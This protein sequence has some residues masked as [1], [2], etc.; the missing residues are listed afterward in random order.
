M[1]RFNWRSGALTLALLGSL[2]TLAACQPPEEPAAP[3]ADSTGPAAG[4]EAMA[5]AEPPALVIDGTEYA[6]AGPAEAQAGLT[7]LTINNAGKEL[8]QVALVQIKDGKAFEDFAAAMAGGGEEYPDFAVPVGGPAVAVPGQQASTFVELEPGYYAM[9]CNIPDATGT[10]HTALGMMR[11]L[12]VAEAAAPS[13]AAPAADVTV[14]GADFKFGTEASYPAGEQVW[15]FDNVGQQ[16][17]ELVLLKLEEGATIGDVAAAFA[18]GGSGQPPALPLGGV[19]GLAP[20]T[21]QAFPV[22]LTA[23]RYGLICFYPDAAS[24][25]VHAE[26]GMMSE[27]D[28]K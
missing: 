22:A 18:P 11:P 19:A 20:G 8:H 1:R 13:A 27:F 10:P 9:L 3:A 23:G 25:K 16:N 4:S 28:V 21:S 17:H 5:P 2:G 24:G 12:R 15:T 14:Q 6:F 26:L 7:E